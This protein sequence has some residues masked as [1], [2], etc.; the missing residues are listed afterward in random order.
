MNRAQLGEA[1]KLLYLNI[2]SVD[3]AGSPLCNFF[4]HFMTERNTYDLKLL[5]IL[6]VLL[7]A[8]EVQDKTVVLVNH[9]DQDMNKSIS[10]Q[11]FTE[12]LD[13]MLDVSLRY[14]PTLGVSPLD[15]K[16]VHIDKMKEYIRQLEKS[17]PILKKNCIKG[18]FGENQSLTRFEFV[19]VF[20][21]NPIYQNLLSASTIRLM[22]YD[23]YKRTSAKDLSE[24][25]SF[26]ILTKNI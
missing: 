15:P 4:N 1:A 26:K 18:I 19:N 11:T 10:V 20:L 21:T 23:I 7:G 5:G 13:I 3:E 24:D 2:D 9:F 8:G 6:A 12:L 25:P 22:L 14:C 17:E 16:L